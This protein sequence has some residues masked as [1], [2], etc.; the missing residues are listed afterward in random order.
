MA[1]YIVFTRESTHDA[2]E[3]DTYMQAVGTTFEGHPV[4]ILAAYGT[5]DVLEG[6][7]P[8]G[9]VIV[10]FPTMADARAWYD[11]PPY[12]AVAQH[13]WRGASYRAVIVQGR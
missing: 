10:E 12:Q 7:A 11:S 8:E 4:K 9:V 5:Q 13:R 2:A 6:L 3:L 1:A